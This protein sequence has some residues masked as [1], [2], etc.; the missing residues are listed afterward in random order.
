MEKA[1]YAIIPANVRYDEKLKDKAKL[2]YGE[3]TALTNEKGFCWASNSYFAD[4]YKVT[5][6][7]ISRLIKNLADGGYVKIEMVYKNREIIGRKIYIQTSIPIDKNVNTY[8]SNNQEGIDQ[9]INTPIDEKVKYN[10]TVYNNTI[11]N[12]LD[13]TISKDID[14]CTKEQ[15]VIK[16]WNELKLNKVIAIKAGTARS[17]MLNARIK[18]YGLKDVIKAIESIENS[19]FL[20]GQNKNN[21]IITFD[22]LLKPNNFSKVLE[23]NYIN[24]NKAEQSNSTSK[25]EKPPLRFNNFEPREYYNDPEKMDKLEK[26]LLGWDDDEAS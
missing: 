10:N 6:E 19:S 18:E 22:W 12:T 23:G 24:R 9:N 8:C 21:W 20:K 1:Y 13:N 2:L 15:Q 3:I 11:N 16:A 26:K 7:T 4:L 5:K 17:K 25:N 14:S